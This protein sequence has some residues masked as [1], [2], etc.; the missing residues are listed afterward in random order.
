MPT[1]N[2]ETKRALID[3]LAQFITANRQ[4]KFKQALAQRTRWLTVVLE[5]IYQSHNASAVVRS[6]ECFGIQDLH[7]I[8]NR[9]RYQINPD[10]TLGSAKW[11]SLH[12]YRDAEG[13]NTRPCLEKLRAEGYL[14]VAT[15]PHQDEY[16][17][18]DLPVN[19][20]LALLFGTEETGLTPEALAMADRFVRIPMFGLTESFNISVS[21][22]LCLYQLSLKLR[23]SACAW[24]LTAEEQTDLELEWLREVLKKRIDI[25]ENAFFTRVLTAATRSSV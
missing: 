5:D 23:Q 22:A 24:N 25:L 16:L 1:F 3:Y 17:L 19:Q 4:A 6:C 12:R 13:G 9:N 2:I 11:I 10:V 20:K 18:P 8:E 21:A 15:T 14:L 7:I